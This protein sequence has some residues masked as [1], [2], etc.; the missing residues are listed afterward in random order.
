M[1]AVLE[2]SK[3]PGKGWTY[4]D[5]CRLDDG[6]RYEILDGELIPVQ[7]P[8]ASYSHQNESG[9]LYV[10]LRSFVA[11]RKLGKVLYAP[12]DVVLD[13]REV[14]QPDL[15]FVAEAR[16]SIVKPEGVFGP[17]DLVVEIVSPSSIRRDRA[18][19]KDIYA[20]FEVPEY[21]LVDHI[22]RTVEV[23]IL[24]N[25]KYVLHAPEAGKVV[26]RVV[27][28]FTVDVAACFEEW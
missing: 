4:A 7:P 13:E 12:F 16:R 9:N 26:S 22:H 10:L 17:P 25:G 15:L 14:L 11:S 8:G 21:W 19:K 20:R 3:R 2:T 6:Q 28:G 18:Q 27:A 24:E 1:S 23:F 5:Y